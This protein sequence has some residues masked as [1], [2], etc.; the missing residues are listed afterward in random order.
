MNECITERLK[1]FRATVLRMQINLGP[2]LPQYVDE[3]ESAEYTPTSSIPAV[4][5]TPSELVMIKALRRF[6]ADM[7]YLK[8]LS[9]VVKAVVADTLITAQK[10]ERAEKTETTSGMIS[11]TND[12]SDDPFINAMEYMTTD[13][14]VLRD[15]M[16]TRRA[17]LDKK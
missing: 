14:D 3:Y 2:L 10:A 17:A 13:H 4:G 1:A 5:E 11:V 7:D 6:D 15:H 8:K 16:N 12:G 9:I